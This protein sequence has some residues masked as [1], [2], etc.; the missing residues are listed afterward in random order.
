MS[1]NYLY[2]LCLKETAFHLQEKYWYLENGNPFSQINC[3]IVNDLFMLLLIELNI[4]TPGA[5]KLLLKSGQLQELML[6]G[7]VFT[8]KQ[9][10]SVMKNPLEEDDSCR[11]ITYIRLPESFQNDDNT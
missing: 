8:E 4:E 9:W 1:P 3:N 6:D 7:H 5:L 11:N 10:R 2:V